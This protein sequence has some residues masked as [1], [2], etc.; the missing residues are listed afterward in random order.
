MTIPFIRCFP[1]GGRGLQ[2]ITRSPKI[3]ALARKF[4]AHD[5]RFLIEILK[6]TT[7]SLIAIIDVNGKAK[8]VAR[9]SCPN[10]PDLPKAVDRLI[11]AAVLQIPLNNPARLLAP[12]Q[13]ANGNLAL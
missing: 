9:E 4:I 7:V 5:G 8:D 6:D 2:E 3:E 11:R 10:G 13:H 12:A 1:G